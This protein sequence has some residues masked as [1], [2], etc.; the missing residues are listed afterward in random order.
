MIFRYNSELCDFFVRYISTN[1]MMI[2]NTLFW[3]L[4]WTI[5]ELTILFGVIFTIYQLVV[6]IISLLKKEYLDSLYKFLT[7]VIFFAICVDMYVFS[8]AMAYGRSEAPIPQYQGEVN[9]KLHDDTIEYFL[10][11]YNYVAS[12]FTYKEDGLI[13]CPYSLRDINELLKEEYK[14]LESTYY[15]PFTS[16]AK[17]LVT[18]DLFSEL[19]FSGINWG[20]S[21]ETMI[22]YNLQD[23]EIP[24]TL[25]HELA[26]NKG[27]YRED[28]ANLVAIY[29]LIT[30]ENEFLRYA[31]YYSGFLS[32]CQIYA[33]E[34][35]NRYADTYFKLNENIRN[36]YGVISKYWNERIDI[37]GKIGQWY[38]DWFLKLNGNQNGTD[39]YIDEGESEDTGET[40]NND[41]PI[42][43]V[44]SYSPY[45]KV[46]IQE[47]IRKTNYVI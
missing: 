35:Y 36:E 16:N 39:D 29:I 2:Q 23:V 10:N 41:R 37:I 28:E 1:Y 46:F 20:P 7:I 43:K 44:T 42:Y 13:N 11:D 14:R 30:S 18:S 22:N 38:N 40:D 31:G 24:H 19:K 8:A 32:L 47:F 34:D 17:T 25:A 6:S 45:Q 27:I 33:L 12:K 3:W 26:H 21:G 9:E 5:Y 4:P 15:N